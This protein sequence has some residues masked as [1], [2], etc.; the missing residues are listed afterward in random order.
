[1]MFLSMLKAS[2]SYS[3][4]DRW[5]PQGDRLAP[6]VI[7]RPCTLEVST[8]WYFTRLS[9]PVLW[10]WSSVSTAMG[11]GS[12]PYMSVLPSCAQV[13]YSNCTTANTGLPFTPSTL[14]SG[15]V[16]SEV[17]SGASEK[18]WRSLPATVASTMGLLLMST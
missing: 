13:V 8:L 4:L 7:H 15:T 3:S 10:S 2:G 6:Q 12:L 1:M 14:A 9:L 16:S 5:V 17:P 11:E 18:Y